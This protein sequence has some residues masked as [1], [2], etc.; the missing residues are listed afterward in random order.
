MEFRIADTFTDSLGRLTGEEQ[1]T[2]TTSYTLPIRISNP[3]AYLENVPIQSTDKDLLQFQVRG[4]KEFRGPPC[5]V[6]LDLSGVNFQASG[7]TTGEVNQENR[8]VRAIDEKWYPDHAL[9]NATKDQLKAMPEFK[10]N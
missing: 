10:Y 4:T 3:A 7:V 9:Y 2:S 6:E 1:K 8:P 5:P